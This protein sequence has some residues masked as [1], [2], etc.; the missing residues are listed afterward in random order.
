MNALIGDI[1]N[2]VT[3]VCL[4]EINTLKIKK[5]ICFNSASISSRNYLKNK[6]RKIIKK[7]SINKIAL[8]SSVVP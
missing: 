8:F 1:G 7:K 4:I 3:K 5:I 2:T 6:F